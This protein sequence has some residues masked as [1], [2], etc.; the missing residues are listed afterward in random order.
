M[1]LIRTEQDIRDNLE[2]FDRELRDERD[3][4]GF[5]HKLVKRGRCFVSYQVGGEWRFAPSRYIG[6]RENSQGRHR[7]SDIDGRVPIKSFQNTSAAILNP[8]TRNPSDWINFPKNSAS[9]STITGTSSFLRAFSSR[10]LWT[11]LTR[12][13]YPRTRPYQRAQ[14]KG[15]TSTCLNAIPNCVRSVSNTGAASAACAVLTFLLP[16]GKLVGGSSMYITLC[17][18]QAFVT[19]IKSIP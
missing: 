2:A 8:T 18:S 4:S 14:Q 12:R 7:R 19:R 11:T 3:T 1:K 15:F 9:G 10:L 13:K 17:L 16:T 5:Y 6:Y